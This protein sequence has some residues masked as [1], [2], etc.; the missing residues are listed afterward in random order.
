ME[1]VHALVLNNRTLALPQRQGV[2]THYTCFSQAFYRKKRS[3]SVEHCVN[4]L[5]METKDFLLILYLNSI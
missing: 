2:P 4:L 1:Y 5:L 3:L